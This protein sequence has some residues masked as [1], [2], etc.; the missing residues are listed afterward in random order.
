MR[1]RALSQKRGRKPKERNPLDPKVRELERENRRLREQLRK[2]EVIID[3]NVKVVVTI[4]RK[5]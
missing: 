3:E 2:E 5:K 4:A 1:C